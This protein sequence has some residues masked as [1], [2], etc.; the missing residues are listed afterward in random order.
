[1]DAWKGDSMKGDPMEQMEQEELQ[2]RQ[3]ASAISVYSD[4]ELEEEMN[5]RVKEKEA[6]AIPQQLSS[7]DLGQLSACCLNYITEIAEGN[8]HEDDDDT[9]YIFEEAMKALYGENIFDW[10]NK[11]PQGD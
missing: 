7:P 11:Q 2:Q 6:A 1:M 4:E 5:R 10:I 9:H 3:K 8:T